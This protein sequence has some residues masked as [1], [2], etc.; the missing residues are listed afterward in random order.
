MTCNC[1]YSPAEPH[2]T[3]Y[4]GWLWRLMLPD[5]IEALR[6]PIDEKVIRGE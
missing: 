6:R 1:E 3:E 5:F 2:A 4:H